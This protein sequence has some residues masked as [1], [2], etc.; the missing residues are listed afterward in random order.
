MAVLSIEIAS[1]EITVSLADY[2]LT[3]PEDASA[4]EAARM[5]EMLTNYF[6]KTRDFIRTQTEMIDALMTDAMQGVAKD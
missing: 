1:G 5:L 3:F 4:A 2:K 6:T